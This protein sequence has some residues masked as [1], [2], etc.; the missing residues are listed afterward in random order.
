[1]STIEYLSCT[2][3]VQAWGLSK[4]GKNKPWG[5]KKIAD[6]C[7]VRK[8]PA[9]E[10]VDQELKN[11]IISESFT[12]ILNGTTNIVMFFGFLLFCLYF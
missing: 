10:V 7:C 5:A 12:K 9:P 1:M 11:K 3:A 6:L 2:D 4:S 8:P